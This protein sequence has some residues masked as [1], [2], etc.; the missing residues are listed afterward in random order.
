VCW[1]TVLLEAAISSKSQAFQQLREVIVLGDFC[2]CNGKT[3]TI[4][5][6]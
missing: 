5:R 2:G 6:Q 1:C 3:S 4:C